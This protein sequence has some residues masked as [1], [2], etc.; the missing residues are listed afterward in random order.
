MIL[1]CSIVGVAVV[2]ACSRVGASELD[3]I[4]DAWQKMQDK[5]QRIKYIAEGET[6]DVQGVYS[7][8]MRG[9]PTATNAPDGPLPSEDYAFRQQAVYLLDFERNLAQGKRLATILVG[10]VCLCAKVSL[11][12]V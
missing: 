2:L 10:H 8:L 5:V 4:F 1:R 9:L 3:Q 12:R 11:V 7:T 6:T